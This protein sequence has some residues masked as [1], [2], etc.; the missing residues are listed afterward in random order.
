LAGTAS[1]N[2][3]NK[4]FKY[5]LQ[6]VF[7]VLIFNFIKKTMMKRI[8]FR[9]WNAWR[10]LVCMLCVFSCSLAVLAQKRING[11]VVDVN[12]EPIIGVNVVEK[13]TTN[14]T[15]TDVDGNFSLSV[16]ENATLQVSYIGYITQEINVLS[17]VGGG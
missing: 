14:G 2:Q 12:D 9:E 15:V 5:E 3:S 13:G 16:K 6:V 7:R 1:L 11:T 17:V 8:F 4:L 10:K